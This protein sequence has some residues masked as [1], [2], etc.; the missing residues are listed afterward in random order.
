MEVF[1]YLGT[2]VIEF[3]IECIAFYQDM[4]TLRF[5]ALWCVCLYP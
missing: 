4:L 2:C 3:Y 5:E 1:D